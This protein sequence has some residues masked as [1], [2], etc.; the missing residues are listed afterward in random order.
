MSLIFLR[1]KPRFA[2]W[3]QDSSGTWGERFS[4]KKAAPNW[5]LIS[6][7]TGKI[8]SHR[9]MRGSVV[10]LLCSIRRRRPGRGK[11]RDF[12]SALVRPLLIRWITPL[13]VT[14]FV[15]PT[16]DDLFGRVVCACVRCGSAVH[17]STSTRSCVH[18]AAVVAG[19]SWR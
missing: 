19:G 12:S 18:L 16:H 9:V 10:L 8:Q 1:D 3:A 7:I 14:S 11:G 13:F 15:A 2:A 4:D 5:R 6:L 17:A